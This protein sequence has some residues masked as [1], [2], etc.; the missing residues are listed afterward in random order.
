MP[1]IVQDLRSAFRLLRTNSGLAI[2]IVVSLALGI[3]ANAA[4]FSLI[5]TLLLRPVPGLKD[6]ERLLALFSV[7]PE[8]PAHL[9]AISHADYLDYAANREI[10]SGLAAY[11]DDAFSFSQGGPSERI[12]GRVVAN[13]YFSVLGIGPVVGRLFV[14]E[15]DPAPIAVLGHG[16]WQRRFGADRDV[17]GRAIM[18]NGHSVTVIGV[19]APGFRGTNHVDSPEIWVTIPTYLGNVTPHGSAESGIAAGPG[20]QFRNL[21]RTRKWLYPVGRLAPG[22]SLEKARSSLAVMAR[23]LAEQYPEVSQGGEVELLP[24]SEIAFGPGKRGTVARYTGLLM[25]MVGV[26][27]LVA[28]LNVANLLL[29]RGLNRQHEITMRLVLGASRGRLVRLLLSESLL[30]ALLG[31]IAGTVVA[32]AALPLLE[33]LELPVETVFTLEFDF[34]V[35][36]FAFLVSLASGLLVGILPALRSSTTALVPAMRGETAG[37]HRVALRDLLVSAQ[38][39]L[40]LLVAI[41]SGLMVRTLRNLESVPLGFDPERVLAASLD[42]SATGSG[43]PEIIAFYQQLSEHVRALAGVEEVGLATALPLVGSDLKVHLTIEPEG[44][45]PPSEDAPPPAA[46]HAVVGAGFFETVGTPL[47]SGRLFGPQDDAAAY[48]VAVV[49]ETMARRYWPGQDAVGRHLGLTGAEKPFRVIGVVA[50]TKY[51]T[52]RETA[53]PILYLEHRQ[54]QQWFVGPLMAPMMTLLVRTPGDPMEVLPAVRRAAQSLDPLLPVFDVTTLPQHLSAAVRIERQAAALFSVFAVLALVLTMVGLYGVIS[55]A[56]MRRTREIGIRVALGALPGA[57]LRLMLVRGV[58]LCLAGIVLGLAAA[59][60]LSRVVSS[61]L[62]GV[63]SG[64]SATYLAVSTAVVA[65]A[66]LVSYL[67]ARRATQIDPVEALRQD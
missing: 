9:G 33:H 32:A 16:L 46:H 13:D 23:R 63:T 12:I 30:L 40:A 52:L 60:P 39:A 54:H 18:L 55:H 62:Y 22:V 41:A 45:K 4:V 43:G 34:R 35:L 20:G 27:L 67:P 7:R 58:G 15:E 24:L 37:R 65:V 26:V 50:D 8:D 6:P 5:D 3:G 51:A 25:A 31:G 44:W 49:N 57:V 53:E 64:D 21:D 10:F 17:I 59:Y 2:A 56:V 11:A 28:C 42:L 48:P 1:T 38:V 47:R 14:P 36:G 19:A 61:Q 29:A 66:V